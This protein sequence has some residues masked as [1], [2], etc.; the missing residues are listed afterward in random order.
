MEKRTYLEVCK[1]SKVFLLESSSKLINTTF[2]IAKS[3][4]KLTH[5]VEFSLLPEGDKSDFCLNFTTSLK[6]IN[7]DKCEYFDVSAKFR[8]HFNVFEKEKNPVEKFEEIAELLGHQLFP[9]IRSFFVDI[10]LKMG[11]PPYLP[12][13]VQQPQATQA[14]KKAISKKEAKPLG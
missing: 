10:L 8:A 14:K 13:S 7:S 9:V 2:D 12:W 11:L 4:L 6:A 1:L 3:E 5:E